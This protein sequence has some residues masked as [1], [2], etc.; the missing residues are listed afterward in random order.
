[1]IVGTIL[2]NMIS[3]VTS[4]SG[5]TKSYLIIPNENYNF[6][7][8]LIVYSC[9]QENLNGVLGIREDN[10]DYRLRIKVMG[11][12]NIVINDISEIIKSIYIYSENYSS[13]FR[14]VKL[15]RETMIYENEYDVYTNNIDFDIN[16]EY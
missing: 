13:N 12:N 15:V 8:P 6:S 3:G 2:Y 14:I 16:Y 10:G 1:M 9:D 11:K 5:C 4:L 7:R